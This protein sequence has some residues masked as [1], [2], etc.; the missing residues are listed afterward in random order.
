MDVNTLHRNLIDG[1]KASEDRLFEALRVRFELLARRR[2]RDSRDA[3][4][5]VQRSLMVVFEKY[6]SMTFEVSFSAW[7]HK[8]LEFEILKLYRT[9]SKIDETFVP[10]EDGGP[11]QASVNPD[12]H[13]KWK[14]VDCMKRLCDTNYRYAK[15]L[16]L[17]F[18][19]FKTGEICDELN[20]TQTNFHVLLSRA[21]AALR[22]CLEN[23]G[24]Q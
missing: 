15:I 24:D 17:R 4:E 20:L 22:R 19:G 6:R 18:Q 23:Q 21:R 12:P 5:V 14:L 10:S 1:D 2:V 16:A 7:A 13:L 9:R 11:P 3:E 8:V